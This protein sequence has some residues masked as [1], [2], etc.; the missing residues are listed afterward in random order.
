MAPVLRTA[1]RAGSTGQWRVDRV[2][3]IMGAPLEQ[4]PALDVVEGD[5]AH[6]DDAI[7]TLRGVTSNERYVTRRERAS[8]TTKQ[9][10]LGRPEATRAVLIPIRKSDAWW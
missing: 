5:G 10:P 8:L 7:W 1:F 4:A 6:A 2:A 3:A 9:Q